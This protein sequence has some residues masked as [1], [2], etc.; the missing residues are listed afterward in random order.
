MLGNKGAKCS[1]LSSLQS[2]AEEGTLM[3]TVIT[4]SLLA[5]VLGLGIVGQASA[6]GCLDT[7]VVIDKWTHLPEGAP[8]GLVGNAALIG[9]DVTTGGGDP[10]FETICTDSG[11]GNGNE[12]V[13]DGDPGNSNPQNNGGDPQ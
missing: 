5:A 10:L 9:S 11:R 4:S 2:I 6:H 13:G 12:P 3:R 7:N 1:R 8:P